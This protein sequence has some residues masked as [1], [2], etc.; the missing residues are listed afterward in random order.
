MA[1]ALSSLIVAGIGTDVGK[2]VVSAFLCQ[3]LGFDYWKPIASGSE[4]GPVDHEVMRGLVSSVSVHIHPPRYVFRKS[5]SPHIAARLEEVS[6]DETALELPSRDRPMVVELAGG[7]AVPI[8]DTLTNLDLVVR[9]RLPVIVVSRHYLGS[10]NH[11]LL[12]MQALRA[13]AIPIAGVLFNGDELPDT[14]RIITLMANVAHLG[15][16]PTMQAVTRE[17]I[18]ELA[19]KI[20]PPLRSQLSCF[21]TS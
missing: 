10:I 4:D 19:R 15:R 6:I 8:S 14:E 9:L 16:I 20:G 21:H 1:G 17:A 7:V 2:T 13:R 11:T 5:L 12:T 18:E 3:A